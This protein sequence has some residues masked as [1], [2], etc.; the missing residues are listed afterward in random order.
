MKV[1][2][3]VTIIMTEEEKGFLEDLYNAIDTTV[4]DQYEGCIGCPFSYGASACLN[5]QFFH[6]LEQISNLE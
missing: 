1:E 5:R 6:N 2:K 3:K 4:C